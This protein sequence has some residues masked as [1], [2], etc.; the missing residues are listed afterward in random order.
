MMP[1]QLWFCRARQYDLCGGIQIW[2][3][4]VKDPPQGLGADHALVTSGPVFSQ[5]MEG[6]E[7][8]SIPQA[9]SSEGVGWYRFL[10][11]STVSRCL[12]ALTLPG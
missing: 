3:V 9:V 7:L 5:G 1:A 2:F 6:Q 4:C 12:M 8:C 11:L 10:A